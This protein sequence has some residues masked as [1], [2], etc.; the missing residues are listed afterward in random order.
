MN[1][2]NDLVQDLLLRVEIEQQAA[3]SLRIELA[4]LKKER[5]LW[6]HM[7]NTRPMALPL[8]RTKKR[9]ALREILGEI[10]KSPHIPNPTTDEQMSS[11]LTCGLDE[12]T[13]YSIMIMLILDYATSIDEDDIGEICKS[14]HTPK[15]QAG[16]V[17]QPIH[18]VS[19][20]EEK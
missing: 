17:D 11:A 1:D 12:F 16:T 8:L 4:R 18:L 19:E 2:S 7:I 14:P 3:A 10:W 20:W 15:P 6:L 5:W 9:T 13:N